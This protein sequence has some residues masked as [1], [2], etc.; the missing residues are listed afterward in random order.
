MAQRTVAGSDLRSKKPSP[1]S[2]SDRDYLEG[3]AEEEIELA[4]QATDPDAVSAHYE[5][6]CR[7][8]DLLHPESGSKPA[9]TKAEAPRKN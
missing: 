6:A 9:E 1:L 2:E 4:R 8:L 5:L 3:R 7:Y